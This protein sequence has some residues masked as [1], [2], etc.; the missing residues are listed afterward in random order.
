MRPP[1]QPS[2]YEVSQSTNSCSDK[3]IKSPVTIL[4][5]PSTAPMAENA[6]QLPSL[7]KNDEISFFFK[8][9]S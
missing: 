6:Q 3:D 8:E 7:L 4:F 9:I 5:M 1:L 2:L